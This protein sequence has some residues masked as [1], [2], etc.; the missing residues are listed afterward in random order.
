MK[1]YIVIKDYDPSSTDINGIPVKVNDIILVIEL[2]SNGF[3]SGKILTNSNNMKYINQIAVFP[4]HILKEMYLPNLPS[5]L[6]TIKKWN[7][8]AILDKKQKKKMLKKPIPSTTKQVNTHIMNVHKYASIDETVKKNVK[9]YRKSVLHK[10]KNLAQVIYDQQEST[11]QSNYYV[12]KMSH[13]NSKLTNKTLYNPLFDAF[14]SYINLKKN[15]HIDLD[16][17][18]IISNISTTHTTNTNTL[19]TTP[20]QNDLLLHKAEVQIKALMNSDIK[21]LIDF[22]FVFCAIC[23]HSKIWSYWYRNLLLAAIDLRCKNNVELLQHISIASETGLFDHSSQTQLFVN[24]SLNRDFIHFFTLLKNKKKK[25]KKSRTTVYNT[26]HIKCVSLFS[27]QS[28]K[29]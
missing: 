23:S 4:L 15:T 28:A 2:L 21:V 19:T 20:H 11:T 5:H 1:R 27:Y 10:D 8:D 9:H 18:S 6:N 13:L 24:S 22:L 29:N 12:K 25:K 16:L 7:Y 14:F 17:Y 26:I 3:C